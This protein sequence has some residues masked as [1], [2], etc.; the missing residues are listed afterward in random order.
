MKS[1]F[2]DEFS[3]DERTSGW[4]GKGLMIWVLDIWSVQGV[5]K[6]CLRAQVGD[7]T[8]ILIFLEHWVPQF[9][10]A[11]L[12]QS[13]MDPGK[14]STV[15]DLIDPSLGTW[16]V[17]VVQAL[18]P[19]PVASAILSL[20]LP[21]D[22]WSDHMVWR[23]EPH[24]RFTV[25]SAY[26]FL[27]CLDAQRETTDARD[28]RFYKML[29]SQ[30]LLKKAWIF[31]WRTFHNLL[32]CYVNLYLKHVVPDKHCF[33][34]GTGQE[35]VL[36]ALIGCS[37]LHSTW[38]LFGW[39]QFTQGHERDFREWMVYVLSH[40]SI[41]ET[42]K[43]FL[44]CS[45]WVARNYQLYQGHISSDVEI[46][47]FVTTYLEELSL[48]SVRPDVVPVPIDRLWTIP[49]VGFIKVNVDGSYDKDLR[50]GG[51]GCVLRDSTGQLLAGYSSGIPHAMDA[52]HVESLACVEGLNLAL[53]LGYR[54]LVVE[55]DSRSVISRVASSQVDCSYGG[56]I[57]DQIWD[58]ATS[59]DRCIFQHVGRDG[60]RVTD[61]FGRE[62]LS[63]VS[64]I[65]LFGSPPP[66]AVPLFAS[67]QAA[68]FS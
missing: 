56:C 65:C 12:L 26:N 22:R 40:L 33:Q 27:L 61:V 9:S 38:G 43:L 55:G 46:H 4:S 23:L 35:S 18:F 14:L 32:P 17:D 7:D 60:N 11:E 66:F 53:S 29:C 64:P 52:F 41:P 28:I 47:G 39:E 36:L 42:H 49:P 10:P 13:C 48:A 8:T 59:F 1:L 20:P 68:L 31:I 50:M 6:Q 62:G 58:L 63:R 19:A 37:Q 54:S 51:I 16:R 44:L 67:D 15:S 24:G 30:P 21:V 57:T 45:L 3:R 2:G 5:I 34:Y 25:R